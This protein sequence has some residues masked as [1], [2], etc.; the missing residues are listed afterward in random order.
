MNPNFSN[1]ALLTPTV[2]HSEFTKNKTKNKKINKKYKHQI[3]FYQKK[4]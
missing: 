3:P 1:Y 2:T 4:S